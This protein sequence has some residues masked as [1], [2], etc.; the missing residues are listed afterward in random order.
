[1]RFLLVFRNAG[2][3]RAFEAPIR[4]LCEGGDEVLVL[5]ESTTELVGPFRRFEIEVDGLTVRPGAA[6]PQDDADTE[7]SASLRTW[8][9]YLRYFEPEF[10]RAT[11]YRERCGRPLPNGV[12][13]QTDRAAGASPELRNALAAGLRAIERS[14]PVSETVIRLL[15]RERP[16]AVLVSPLLKRGSPQTPYL[17]AARRLGIPSGLCVAGWDDLMTRGVIH[18]P[19][20]LVT[21]WNDAQRDEAVRLHG[22]PTDRVAVTGPPR[23]DAWFGRAP[24]TSRDDYCRRLGIPAD[25]PHL[26]YVCSPRFTAPDEGEWIS[27]WVSNLR[28]SAHPELRD[29]PI[30]VRPH[31][32]VPPQG[33]SK[34]A[35]RLARL[36]GVLVDPPTGSRE[37]DDATLSQY[38]DAIHHSAAVVGINT[39][40]MIDA[41]VVGR[42]V[43]VPLT[44]R[45]RA[46]Q[47]DSP[48]FNRL[49]SVG[50]GLVVAS[51][52]REEHQRGLARALR[53]DDAVQVAE[54]TRSFLASFIRPHGLDQPATP[55]M[56]DSLRRLAAQPVEATGPQTSDLV[57]ALRSVLVRERPNASSSRSLRGG[58]ASPEDLEGKC[59]APQ[60]ESL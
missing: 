35:R 25:R 54:R 31:P 3:L 9:D 30:L 45:Y 12:R 60:W 18:E 5:L 59:P 1:M 7:L 17:R 58:E 48:H 42:S 16:D 34:R 11:K 15:E 33:D 47:E 23:F 2:G 22:V 19:P 4:S 50:G 55:V 38:F 36:P 8:I 37:I 39:T 32:G 27:R 24:S 57:D 29:V 46:T 10:E 41:G 52:D 53:G 56:V 28:G 43:H 20:D 6:A 21:V 51:D 40:A 26:L 49:R 44:K 14:V 13:E